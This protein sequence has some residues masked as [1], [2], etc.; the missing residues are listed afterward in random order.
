MS[1]RLDLARTL[2]NVALDA[3]SA[4]NVAVEHG[5]LALVRS[6]TFNRRQ[7][8]LLAH[9]FTDLTELMTNLSEDPPK[10][11]CVESIDKR[12]HL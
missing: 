5:C 11:F 2:M 10:T 3:E 8:Q 7:Q 6:L 9:V 1:N 12:Q 4:E